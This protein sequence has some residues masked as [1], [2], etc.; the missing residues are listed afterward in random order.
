MHRAKFWANPVRYPIVP[1]GMDRVRISIHVDNTREQIE[2]VIEVIMEWA[3]Y[4]A[5][6][7]RKARL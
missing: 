6:Q 5:E 3:T 2:D 7:T 1:K 4:R